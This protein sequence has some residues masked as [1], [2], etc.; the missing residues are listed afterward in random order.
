MSN[1][2]IKIIVD[3]QEFQSKYVENKFKRAKKKKIKRVFIALFLVTLFVVSSVIVFFKNVVNPI[4]LAFGEAQINK[5]LVASSNN[6]ISEIANVNYSD[7]VEVTYAS[8]GEVLSIKA[9]IGEINKIGNTLALHTQAKID[10]MALLGVNIP[11]GT[12]SG[13]AFLSGVGSD[14]TFKITPIGNAKC[15]FYTSFSSCGINQ[16]SHKIFVTIVSEAS[17]ILPFGIK[18]VKSQNSYVASEFV[19]VG[20]VPNTYFNVTSIDDLK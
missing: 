17:L 19:I 8:S 5:M 7:L 4:V 12:L 9:N 15:V 14:V 2:V 20:K 13:V 11:L 18:V 16:T 1:F 3:C 10:E 6:A